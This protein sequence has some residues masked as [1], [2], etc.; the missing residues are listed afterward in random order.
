MVWQIEARIA[1]N[2]DGGAAEALLTLPPDQN[3]FEM[4]SETGASPGFGFAIDRA[5]PQRR[6]HWTKRNVEG[7]QTLFYKLDLVQD[8]GRRVTEERPKRRRAESFDGAYA[9]V[10]MR[11]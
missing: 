3:G 4:L 9:T 2:A 11:Y 10:P 8:R 5:G 7:R 1:F 6:A